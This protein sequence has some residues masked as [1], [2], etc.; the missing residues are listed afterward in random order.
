MKKI[1]TV[2][3]FLLL[4]IIILLRLEDII[5]IKQ[6]SYN[7]DQFYKEKNNIDVFFLGSSFAQYGI[8]PMEIWDKYGIVSYN[9]A[10][11]Q[12]HYKFTY[13]LLE[14]ILLK[15]KPKVVV[16][17]TYYLEWMDSQWKWLDVGLANLEN[18]LFKYDAYKY[19]YGSST[20]SLSELFGT[21]NK[22][23]TNWKELNKYNY[24]SESYWKGK[25]SGTARS[26]DKWDKFHLIN[27]AERYIND[28]VAE[29][30]LD[31]QTKIYAKKLVDIGNKHNCEV[32]FIRMPASTSD[33]GLGKNKAF[34][35]YADENGWTFI[36]YQL[37]YDELK[38]DFKRDFRDFSHLNLYGG[39]KFA[40][41]L[42]PYL[43]KQY[44]IPIRKNDPNYDKW[45]DDYIHY[46]R[47]INKAEITELTEFNEWKEHA[48]YDNYTVMI[49]AH[50]DVM[51]HL[52]KN[53]KLFLKSHLLNKYETD[54][55]D[56]SYVAI[57]DDNDVFFEH[58]SSSRVAFEGRMKKK[59]NLIVSSYYQGST[60]YVSG[61][62]LSKRRYGLNI[63][64][65]DKVNKEVVDSIWIDPGKPN[66]VRR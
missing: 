66:E 19:I 43:I 11:T 28:N 45:N 39:R 41:S 15:H 59:V 52:P 23:H 9:R 42:I 38:L 61:K 29:L 18:S 7:I 62:Q 2:I 32:I 48:F 26:I 5:K 21:F 12:Q 65:Y 55:A 33:K 20:K 47:A 17:D 6:Y 56:Q 35:R 13:I 31:E 64:V 44:N 8:S 54:Y 50:G 16:I 53:L 14:E 34:K 58:L 40:D 63:V 37:K 27:E 22:Y 49:S 60:I 24:I 46:A 30:A 4:L 10:T 57:I 3:F 1:F 25:Y 51:R 36:N